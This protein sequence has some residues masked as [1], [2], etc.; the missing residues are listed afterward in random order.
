[1]LDN[2]WS[3][4]SFKDIKNGNIQ[5]IYKVDYIDFYEQIINYVKNN[6]LTYSCMQWFNLPLLRSSFYDSKYW[7]IIW[8]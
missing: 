6:K 2:A 3:D 8:W 5:L 4:N 7:Y 1:M